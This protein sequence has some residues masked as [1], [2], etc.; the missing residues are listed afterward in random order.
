MFI[1]IPGII[2]KALT[3]SHE[4][5][6]TKHTRLSGVYKT[7]EYGVRVQYAAEDATASLNKA[8]IKMLQ[9]VVRS[10]LYYTRAV[11]PTMLTTTNTIASEQATPTEAGCAP[12]AICSCAP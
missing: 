9:E 3:R 6:G 10:L 1:S 12:A 2:N 5:T 11:D 4:W 8:D 7:S